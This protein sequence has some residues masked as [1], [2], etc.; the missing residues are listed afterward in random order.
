M[1]KWLKPILFAFVFFNPIVLLLLFKNYW[2]AIFIPLAII[3]GGYYVSKMKSFRLVVWLFNIFAIVGIALCAELIFRTLYPTK[4]VPNIY[5][6]RGNYYFNKPYLNQKFEDEE[7]NSRYLTN[8][9]GYRIDLL[10]NPSDSIRRCDWIFI[11]DSFTQGAQVNYDEMFTSLVYKDFPDKVIVNAGM[12]GAGLY[13][14]LNYLKDKG[15]ELKPQ[16]VILQIGTFNDFYNIVERHAGLSEY[17]MEHSDLYRYIQYNLF[18]SPT[19]PLG[20]W[21]EPFFDNPEENSKFN[22]F[23][24]QSSDQKETDRSAFKEILAKFKNE[25]DKIGAE[26]VVMLIPSKEQTSE[27]MLTE[28]LNK[29]N[30]KSDEVDMTAPNELTKEICQTLDIPLIDLYNPF[31]ASSKFPFYQRDEHLNQVGHQII[32]HELK[33]T[34]NGES[35]R[36]ETFSMGNRNERYPTFY[37]DGVSVLYQSQESEVYRIETSNLIHTRAD[38]VW[39]S[40]KNLIHPMISK[41]SKWLVFTQGDQDKGETDVILF[42][43]DSGIDTKVNP[44]GFRGAIPTFSNDS[45]YLAYPKWRDNENPVI[46]VYDIEASKEIAEIGKR[47]T[48]LWRPIFS[49]NDKIV[50]FIEM[51]D[52]G[53]FEIK[54]FDIASGNISDILKTDYNIWDIAISP[55]GEKICYAGNKDGNWDL[56]LYDIPTKKIRQLT[57]SI[58]NEWD[59][60]FYSEDEIWFAGEFGTNNGIYHIRIN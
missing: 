38:L 44:L 28:V 45:R 13:E 12:S 25:T 22:I 54:G 8:C 31:R 41:D 49:P 50:Y 4:N 30:I 23:Y 58:G 51:N 2:I 10:S 33:S 53:H 57:K 36:Y 47:N 55:S 19:L 27:E 5:E 43:R 6:T 52:R 11:G 7:F 37:D 42:N 60:V 24:R 32:A 46:A 9:Q 3:I 20:R 39:E 29:F 59:P 15:K 48:E 1:M 56:F 18:D 21:T 16:R 34:F 17:L 14:S 26:L 35:G 40:P